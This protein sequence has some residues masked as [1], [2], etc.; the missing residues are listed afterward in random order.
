[1]AEKSPFVIL[2]V[3]ED[4]TQN[5]LTEAYE[6]LKKKYSDLRFEAGEVGSDACDKLDEI[7]EAYARACEELRTRFDIR[8][9]GS[10]LSDVDRAIKENRLDDAQRILDDC[11]ER[12]ARWHYLQSAVFYK[13]GWAQDALRQLDFACEMEPDNR[14]YADARKNMSEHIAADSSARHSFYREEGNGERSYSRME[15]GPSR[16]CGIC[17]CC[18]TLL[19]ADCCCE[20]MGGDLIG[21][22]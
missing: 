2:G 1:M 13:K 20:C 19:C 22:C 21:C 7:E 12:N 4:C 17:D 16:G 3:S 5:D 9:T 6:A 8:Y 18:T 14:T 10:D 15:D 11:A